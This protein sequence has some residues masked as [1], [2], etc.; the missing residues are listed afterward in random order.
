MRGLT[1]RQVEGSVD[2]AEDCA[3]HD[4]GFAYAQEHDIE[5]DNGCKSASGSYV[6]GCEAYGQQI[7]QCVNAAREA[8]MQGKQPANLCPML[9]QGSG[10]RATLHSAG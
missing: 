2:C 3:G 9:G 6:E 5:D 4:A 1:Y 10:P 8:V 7:E